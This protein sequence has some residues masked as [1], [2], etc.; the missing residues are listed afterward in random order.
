MKKSTVVLGIVLLSACSSIKKDYT[1]TSC[2]YLPEPK[3]V[4]KESQK[5]DNEY[6]YFVAKAENSNQRLCEKTASARASAVIASEIATTITNAY[7]NVIESSDDEYKDISSETLEQNIEMYLAG[8]EQAES[9]WQKRKY[10]KELGAEKDISK[11]Q[12]YALLKMNKKNYE[13]VVDLSLNKMMQLL[14][15]NDENLK[16]KVKNE[17]LNADE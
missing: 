1:I 14:Q 15:N 13:K 7:N 12:C 17:V 5:A 8:V 10:S 3:W 9:Y 2:S 11:Y 6:K 4:K 16:N